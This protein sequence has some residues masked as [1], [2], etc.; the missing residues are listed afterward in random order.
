M[1]IMWR[2]L[3]SEKG[4]TYGTV[5]KYI[6]FNIQHFR[7]Y[8]NCVYNAEMVSRQKAKKKYKKNTKK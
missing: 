3:L 1:M 2:L 7:N 5:S 6:F 4:K 8:I